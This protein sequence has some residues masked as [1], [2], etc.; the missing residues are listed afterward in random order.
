M[1]PQSRN[2][3]I[4]RELAALLREGVLTETLY[5][6]L[7]ER[8]PTEGWDWRSLGRWFL[9][10]GAVSIMANWRFYWGLPRW[11]VSV[12]GNGSSTADRR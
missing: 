10:F 2:R 11:P 4:C 6:Q 1:N 7:V 12:A 5:A 8:Y 3:S 9:I